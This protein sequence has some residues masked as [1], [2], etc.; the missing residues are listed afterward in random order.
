[1]NPAQQPAP[2]AFDR[3]VALRDMLRGVPRAA[4]E[5]AMELSIGRAW[6]I[7]GNDQF[8]LREG[9]DAIEGALC[10]APLVV[11]IENVG[12]LLAPVAQQEAIVAAA[13]WLALLL[14]ASNRY[15][16]AADLHLETVHADHRELMA[17]HAA[18]LESEARYRLLNAELE[19]R[20]RAQVG[21][22]EQSQRRMYMAEKMASIGN[23]AAGMAHEINNPIGFIRS[24]LCTAQSYVALLS[25]AVGDPPPPKLAYVVEDFGS[26]LDESI[27]GADR[28]GRIIADLKAYAASDAARLE[29][30]DPNQAIAAALRM[31]GDLPDGVRLETS[32]LDLPSLHC[33]IDGLKRVVLALLLNARWAME[34]RS[35][36]IRLSS[37]IHG[38]E[39]EI[40]VADEGCGIEPDIL[41]RIFDPFFTTRAIG[42][43]MGLGLTVASDVVRAHNG[44]I[45][46]DSSPGLG[47]T[48][49]VRIPM[50][51]GDA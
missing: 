35:G 49:V 29:L 14:G 1:M 38:R 18:L 33:D 28:V 7:A 43:G 23:L 39:L 21:L 30:A 34:G 50:T 45:G 25:Q 47:T 2:Q 42:S 51:Q 10:T 40:S 19:A 4:L 37:A 27:S 46:V 8:V 48:F 13:S 16:M 3:Q 41:G 32:L 24:N 17:K 26:L 12:V 15:R 36:T 6:R 44:H 5:R 9:P 11:D 22:V 31:L 20:V